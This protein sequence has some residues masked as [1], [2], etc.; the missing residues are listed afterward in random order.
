VGWRAESVVKRLA[1][2]GYFED[3]A[4][5]DGGA[6]QNRGD[7]DHGLDDPAEN[8]A[9]HQGAEINGAKAAEE[10]GGFACVAEFDKFDIGENFGTAPVTSEEE[11]GH[12]AAEA[13]RPPQPVAGDAVFGDEAGDEKWSISGESGGDHGGAGEPPGDVSAGDEKFFGAAGGAAA[14]VQADQEIEQ[15]VGGDDNPVGGGER[16]FYFLVVP[17]ALY[18]EEGT[19]EQS[20]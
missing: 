6:E 14:V 19:Q 9:V 2:D 12:H 3:A 15:Q 7:A 10:C 11:D 4:G 16:H 17:A 1:G 20:F 13:L 8:E 18:Y 5:G